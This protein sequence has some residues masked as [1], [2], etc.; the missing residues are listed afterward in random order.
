MFLCCSYVQWEVAQQLLQDNLLLDLLLDLLLFS[1]SKLVESLQAMKG[2][3]GAFFWGSWWD[4]GVLVGLYS[5]G[6]EMAQNCCL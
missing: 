5:A 4:L 3:G 2:L 6:T 1:N